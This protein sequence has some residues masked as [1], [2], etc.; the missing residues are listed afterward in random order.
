MSK[1]SIDFLDITFIRTIVNC[2]NKNKLL[3]VKS[4]HFLWN[5]FYIPSTLQLKSFID[6][7][8]EKVDDGNQDI[9]N[10]LELGLNEALVNAVVHGNSGD[11]GKSIRIRRIITPN[12]FI[13]QIQDEGNGVPVKSRIGSLPTNLDSINGRGLFLIHQCFDDVRWSKE[14]NRLQVASRR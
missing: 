14:G 10:K 5:D 13:W 7:L 6:L 1:Q 12:W 2:F 8:L 9:Y 4:N 3:D 11:Q